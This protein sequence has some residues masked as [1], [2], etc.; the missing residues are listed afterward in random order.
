MQSVIQAMLIH[1]LMI[2]QWPCSLL[3]QMS[4]WIRNFIWTGSCDTRKMIC[5]SWHH[6]CAPKEFGGLGIR[7][8]SLLNRAALLKTSWNILTSSSIWCKFLKGRFQLSSYNWSQTYSKSSIWRGLKAMI[9]TLADGCRWVVG[10]GRK[11]NLWRDM[12]DSIVSLLNINN[13]SMNLNSSVSALIFDGAWYILDHFQASFPQ[14]VSDIKNTELPIVD[15][16]DKMVW[17]HSADGD[18]TLKLCM[19]YSKISCGL[20]LQHLIPNGP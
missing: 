5:I 15:T 18:I 11:I 19:I 12:S 7:D 14:L 10:D 20:K 1:S 16:E 17:C 9:P 3:K 13:L 6:V 2:Y 8:L 4:G